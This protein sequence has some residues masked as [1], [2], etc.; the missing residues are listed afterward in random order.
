MIALGNE[1]KRFPFIEYSE[2]L[3]VFVLR[4]SKNESYKMDTEFGK[5]EA[6]TAN[7]TL[8]KLLNDGFNWK[9]K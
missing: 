3:G 7:Q 8:K 9:R 1:D 6:Y 2:K 4:L 5:K